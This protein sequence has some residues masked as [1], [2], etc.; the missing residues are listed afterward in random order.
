[1]V[2]MDQIAINSARR[3]RF[4]QDSN[5][6]LHEKELFKMLVDP[7]RASQIYILKQEDPFLTAINYGFIEDKDFFMKTHL[8]FRDTGYTIDLITRTFQEM[9]YLELNP[10]EELPIRYHY[11][12]LNSI[13]ERI[14]EEGFEERP[15]SR[16][17]RMEGFINIWLPKV[18]EAKNITEERAL[19]RFG[20][21]ITGE[22][23]LMNQILGFNHRSI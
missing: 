1:M 12:G 14:I 20:P 6:F 16:Y 18:S 5:T 15:S 21:Y 19:K 11:N 3:A 8:L 2:N 10:C 13:I 17:E 23:R 4:S 22:L 9:P 7:R